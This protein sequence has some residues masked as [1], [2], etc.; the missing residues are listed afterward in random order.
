M[1]LLAFMKYSH[2]LRALLLSSYFAWKAAPATLL[3]NAKIF[4]KATASRVVGPPSFHHSH[5]E[6]CALILLPSCIIGCLQ[7]VLR[8]R[9]HVA[10]SRI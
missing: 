2:V 4:D 3:I 10:A 5:Y 6:F 8:H 9:C 7:C 1:H